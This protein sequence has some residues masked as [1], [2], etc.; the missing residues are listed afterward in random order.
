MPLYV[1]N[2]Y[3]VS[4]L[5]YC[6]HSQINDFLHF[7]AADSGFKSHSNSPKSRSECKDQGLQLHTG[8]SESQ[9]QSLAFVCVCVCVFLGLHP[10]QMEVPRR[11]VQLELEPP[12]YTRATA[13]L[14]PSHICNLYHSSRQ[15]QIFNP[16][17]KT[18]GGTL[19]LMDA[20]W[21]C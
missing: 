12:A 19:V 6:L 17:S 16:L 8:N 1:P 18:R 2:I 5:Q 14:D 4:N 10:Q 21:F 20:S 13:M 7:W 11:G 3:I 15:H 9:I